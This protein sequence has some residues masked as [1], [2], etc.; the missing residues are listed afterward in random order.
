MLRSLMLLRASGNDRHVY[1]L[2]PT[3]SWKIIMEGVY[4]A[5][6]DLFLSDRFCLYRY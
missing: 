4:H 6:V 1:K 3:T 5:G 2:H